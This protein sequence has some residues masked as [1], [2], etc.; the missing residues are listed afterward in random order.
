M[1]HIPTWFE[2]F[3]LI[4]LFIFACA[5]PL[6]SVAWA[7]GYPNKPVHLIVQ[8]SP[9]GMPD[10][11]G[12]IMSAELSKLWN[13]SVVV[14]NRTGAS[15]AI[16]TE[17]VAKAAPDGYTLLFTADTPITTAPTLLKVSYEPLRDLRPIINVVVVQGGFVLTVHPSMPAPNLKELIAWIRA[18][19]G[20]ASFASSGSG[21]AQHLC[22]ELIR[23][24]AGGLDMIHVPYK[25]FGQGLADV[26]AGQVSMIFSNAPVAIQMAKSGKA[27]F[28]AAT[29]R[30][31]VKALPEVHPVAEDLPG[32]EIPDPWYGFMGPAGLPREIVS[33]IHAD[34]VTI[35]KRADFQE[36]LIRDG[37]VHVPNTPEEFA[38]QLKADLVT[39]ASVLKTTG[40]KVE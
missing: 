38:A 37:L 7:Q 40:V 20:K 8:F 12:R 11:Y 17:A 23:K 14:E 27:K 31:G 22:M 35:V 29:G 21:S 15:G 13:Q 1:K 6:S 3:A 34:V 4:T 10:T 16:G 26:F 2:K 28:I 19:N 18:Q 5:T 24:L 36:R 30:L 39:W 25:G 9:G 32:F 33:K